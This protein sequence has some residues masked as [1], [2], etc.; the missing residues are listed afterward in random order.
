MKM[1]DVYVC[2]SCGTV[3]GEDDFTGECK[4]C[5]DTEVFTI[6]QYRDFYYAWSKLQE[7]YDNLIVVLD[8]EDY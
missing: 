2:A 6:E 8:G 7:D 3:D 4:N 1:N 5:G